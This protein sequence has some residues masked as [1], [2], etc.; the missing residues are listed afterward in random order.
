VN[1]VASTRRLRWWRELLYVLAFYGVYTLVRNRGLDPDA[2]VQAYH[3]ALRVIRAEQWLHSFHEAW[4]Q[5]LFYPSAKWF[6]K[7]WNVYYGSAHF[8]V[9]VIAIVWLFR[10]DPR[11]YPLWR[12]T[13][14]FTTG[15]ALIGF[16]FFP[17]MP[18]RLLDMA[19][20]L[21]GGRHFHF[22]DTLQVVG[23]LW[24]F[25]SGTMQKISNQYAAMP[26]LHFGW[27]SWCALVLYPLVRR[28][29]VKALVLAYPFL[30]LF[31]IVVT[32]NHYW[33]DAAGGAVVLA[34]GFALARWFTAFTERRLGPTNGADVDGLFDPLEPA[35]AGPAEVEAT[36]GPGDGG[37]HVGGGQDLTTPR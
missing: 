35:A 31:A 33:L 4:V 8:I 37:T 13:L 34:I 36:R 17:L 9:T 11:R 7:F 29:W 32:A 3:N 22:V 5:H 14:A 12:N 21:G 28:R 20:P 2:H 25:D 24:S 18:P 30:T 23:G 15:L 19:P 26:S 16:A 27:S 1:S 10:R 6:L